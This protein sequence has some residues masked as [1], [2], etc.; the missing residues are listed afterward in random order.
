[1]DSLAA[2]FQGSHLGDAAI[3][4]Q[5]AAIKFLELVTVFGLSDRL[6]TG[7]FAWC[8]AGVAC[9]LNVVLSAQWIDPAS[10]A[11]EVAGNQREIAQALDV[12]HAADV[13]GDP[14]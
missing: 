12:V 10:F 7:I 2:H 6:I 11:S 13:F 5:F 9:A 14:K 1:M 3:R 4:I 8:G